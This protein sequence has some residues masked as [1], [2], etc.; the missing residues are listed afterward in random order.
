VSGCTGVVLDGS[1]KLW[2]L[3]SLF[4]C[5]HFFFADVDGIET[6]PAPTFPLAT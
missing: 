5:Q 4:L 6:I 1:L 3:N 2:L